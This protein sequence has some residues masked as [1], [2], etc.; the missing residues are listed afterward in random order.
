MNPAAHPATPK[1]NLKQGVAFQ[2]ARGYIAPVAAN[3]ATGFGDSISKRR[4]GAPMTIAGAFFVPADPCY[5]GCVRETFGSA[6]FRLPR[7]AN[8]RTAATLNRLATIRGSSFQV[9]GASPLHALN[10]SKIR[11]AAHRAMAIAALHADSSLSVRL[12]R[13]NAA[14]AKARALE[15][16]GGA[17]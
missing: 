13:Y 3:S 8:L 7:F 6:G 10:P 5:G 17:Q 14:M 11:A 12:K 2:N 9:N 4:I 1:L 15:A 16:V